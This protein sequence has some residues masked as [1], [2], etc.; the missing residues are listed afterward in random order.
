MG[1]SVDGI[2]RASCIGCKQEFKCG[3]NYVTSHLHR[4]IS[5]CNLVSFKNI[6][7]MII[8]Q[9]GKVRSK[10]IDQLV[11]REM[12]AQA[13]IEHDLPYSFVEYRKIVAWVKYLNPD[14]IMPSRNTIVSD[15]NKIYENEKSKLKEEMVNIPNRIC[16]TSDVWTTCTSEGMGF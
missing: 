10:K 14:V 12:C 2:E 1:K 16:L 15:V 8:G 7:Q 9:E 13:I 5:S 3:G 6:Q 4:H 11:S